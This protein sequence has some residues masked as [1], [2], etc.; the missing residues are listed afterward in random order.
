MHYL[1]LRGTDLR[2]LQEALSDAIQVMGGAGYTRDTPVEM[3]YRDN[4][5]NAI[6]EGTEGIQGNDL[7]GRKLTQA[8]GRG[9]EVLLTRIGADLSASG[10]LDGLHEIRAALEAAVGHS[11]DALKAILGRAA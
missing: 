4:R 8:G 2:P 11:R 5:I 6:H 9:L 10:N 3:Y 1:A 7:L